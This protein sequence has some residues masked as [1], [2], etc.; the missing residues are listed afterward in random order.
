MFTGFFEGASARVNEVASALSPYVIGAGV[1]AAVAVVVVALVRHIRMARLSPGEQE[2]PESAVP[3]EEAA[4]AEG[5]ESASRSSTSGARGTAAHPPEKIL[6][7]IPAEGKSQ[8]ELESARALIEELTNGKARVEPVYGKTAQENIEIV[9][10]LARDRRVRF[11]RLLDTQNLDQ[12]AIAVA[13]ESIVQDLKL[14]RRELRSIQRFLRLPQIEK[15]DIDKLLRVLRERTLRHDPSLRYAYSQNA[16]GF[17]KAQTQAAS[18]TTQGVAEA[19]LSW[20]ARIEARWKRMGITDKR[21]DPIKEYLVITDRKFDRKGVDR[22]L[23]ARGLDRYIDSRNVLFEETSTSEVVARVQR[24]NPGLGLDRIGIRTLEQEEN[25][26]IDRDDVVTLKLG[27]VTT[28]SGQELYVNINMYEVLFELLA[29]SE[30]PQVPGLENE[31]GT[32]K[33]YLYLPPIVPHDYEKEMT[34]YRLTVERI[35]T[36]A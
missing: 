21:D 8:S 14:D 27:K 36:A 30:K 26:T 7:G 1:V 35:M 13:L 23:I 19:G 3:R 20:A 6:I 28:T 12:E 17:F 32:Q 18:I 2:V 15:V 11:G 29:A 10:A 22:Y 33:I 4:P 9:T 5:G 16:E 24:D 34:R 31:K 25:F